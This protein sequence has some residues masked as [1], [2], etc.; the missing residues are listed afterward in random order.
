MNHTV[1][2]LK[3]YFR[4]SIHTWAWVNDL[5]F[6]WFPLKFIF[7]SI[8]R[9]EVTNKF[10]SASWLR[11]SAAEFPP[12]NEKICAQ[13]LFSKLVN[14]HNFFLYCKQ[15]T[16]VSSTRK[17]SGNF[18]FLK[19]WTLMNF[20]LLFEFQLKFWIRLKLNHSTGLIWTLFLATQNSNNFSE[21]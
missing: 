9:V 18:L 5:K 1:R 11:L 7:Y 6:L 14:N 10:Q 17:I 2:S 8:L 15:L 21:L 4:I 12:P 13:N 20:L 19:T 16:I 3:V